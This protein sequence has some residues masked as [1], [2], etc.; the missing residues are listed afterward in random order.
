MEAVFAGTRSAKDA[1]ANMQQ[2]DNQLLEQFEQAN[3]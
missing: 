1:L 3:R 2:R